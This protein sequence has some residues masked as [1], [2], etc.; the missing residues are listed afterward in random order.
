MRSDADPF[1]GGDRKSLT[2]E[3]GHMSY[4]SATFTW[5]CP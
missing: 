3:T 4:D 5:V 2:I 1:N